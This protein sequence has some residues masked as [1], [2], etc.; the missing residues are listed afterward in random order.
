MTTETNEQGANVQPEKDQSM[1]KRSLPVFAIIN[2]L[3]FVGLVVLY[4]LFF[5]RTDQV[6]DHQEQLTQIEKQISGSVSS[7]A[8]V[9][10]DVLMEEY[11]LAIIMR[12]DFEEEQRRLERDL[13]R[14]Q[15][16]F[17]TEVEGFQRSINAGTISLDRAQERE[18]ELMLM[19]QE[20]MQ[21]NDTYRERLAIKEFEMNVELL[22]KI[23]DFLERYNKEA[24]HDFI[25]GYS[26]GGGILFADQ[27]HDITQNVLRLLNAEYLDSE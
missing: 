9:N 8:Y 26:R 11:E 13:N 2:A 20:L 1:A 22:E 3:L 10:S 16:T 18:Q 24:G 27:S 17:Q 25:L 14:R 6:E 4:F 12:V 21:L 15:R 5:T 7:I 23:S 19:Q